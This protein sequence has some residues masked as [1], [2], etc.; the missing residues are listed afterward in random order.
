ME[1]KF[2][3]FEYTI[4]AYP[5]DMN[6]EEIALEDFPVVFRAWF[7]QGYAQWVKAEIG[8]LVIDHPRAIMM[9]GLDNLQ[10]FQAEAYDHAL[11]L[12]EEGSL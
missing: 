12:R 4:T 6:G 8:G 11:E 3:E 1:Y 7:T 5:K 10:R 9:L 2:P